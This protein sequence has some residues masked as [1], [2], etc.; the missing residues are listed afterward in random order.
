MFV[1]I[2]KKIK[3]V[4]S[5][6]FGVGVFISF[7]ISLFVFASIEE[8]SYWYDGAIIVFLGFLVIIIGSVISWLNSFMLY[9]FGEL[10][11]KTCEIAEN[12]RRGS[13]VEQEV[14]ENDEK[15]QLL[16]KWM[17]EGLISEEEYKKKKAALRGK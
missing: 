17:R 1:D 4:A 5:F 15:I 9:G 10:I 12:T 8:W 11:D 13:T 7:L 14:C 6:I 3:G 2:G 16:E